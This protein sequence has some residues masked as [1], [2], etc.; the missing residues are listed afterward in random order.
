MRRA[1]RAVLAGVALALVAGGMAFAEAPSYRVEAGDTLIDIAARLGVSARELV[2]ENDL[3]DGDL[4]RPGQVLRVPGGE[5]RSA[6]SSRG[7]RVEPAARPVA[8]SFVWPLRGAI[9]TYFG[10]PGPFWRRGYHPGLDIAGPI[11][12]QIAAAGEGVVIEAESSG[13]NRGYGSYVKI[14]H[15]G[16]VQTLYAHLARVQVEAGEQV[17]A[18]E[19]VGAVGM[20]GFT[21]GPHLHLEVRVDGQIQDPLRWLP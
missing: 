15:G 13:Y 20:T 21:T 2:R 9:T 10:E 12:A 18:G 7:S 11:G 19:P 14:D 16:G 8:G 17:A 4:I 6:P 1:I 5:A 3:S